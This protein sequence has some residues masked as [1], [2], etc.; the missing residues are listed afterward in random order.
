M[1]SRGTELSAA[2]DGGGVE[3]L[4]MTTPGGL[5]GGL[6]VGSSCVFWTEGTDQPDGSVRAI[7]R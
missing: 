4:Y 7:S 5:G 3:T 1:S 6:A 2:P